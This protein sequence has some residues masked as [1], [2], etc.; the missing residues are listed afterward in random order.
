M[1]TLLVMLEGFGEWRTALVE[2]YPWLTAV[3]TIVSL[4]AAAWAALSWTHRRMVA[5]AQRIREDAEA[6]NRGL[7]ADKARLQTYIADLDEQIDTLKARLPEAAWAP[8]ERERRD[9]HEK[10]AIRTLRRHVDTEGA[11][12]VDASTA[13]ER[14]HYRSAHALTNTVFHSAQ[15]WALGVRE[16]LALTSQYWCAMAL[17]R[18]GRFGE[19]LAEID[20][21]DGVPGILRLYEQNR[22][23]Q[24]MLARILFARRLRASVL[25]GLGRYLQALAEI[26]GSKDWLGALSYFQQSTD[27]GPMHIHTLDT[28]WLR[29]DVLLALGRYDHALAEIDGVHGQQGVL[30]AEEQSPDLGQTHPLTLSTRSLRAD[31]LGSLG[32]FDEAL[33]E[34]DGT[35]QRLGV[36]SL[37]EQNPDLGPKH[38]HTL[39]TRSLRGAILCDLGRGEE[40]ERELRSVGAEQEE[41]LGVHPSTLKSAHRLARALIALSR[42][43][44]AD[45]LLRVVI[46][47]CRDTLGDQHP[48]TRVAIADLK[49]LHQGQSQETA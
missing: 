29:A 23:F 39:N 2:M 35:G 11:L 28:R 21:D 20:G 19:A 10:A 47:G 3:A 4:V 49:L 32:R 46:A 9:D 40:S 13:I 1:E 30:R 43:A 45:E 41:A 25:L 18:L 5:E 31:V 15:R 6:E 34:I 44:E 12:L 33:A 36:L 14:G 42:L 17:Q 26:D 37:Q 7:K 48:H 16:P 38:P 8:A 24:P 27:F 22:D